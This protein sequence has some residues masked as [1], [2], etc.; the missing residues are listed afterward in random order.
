M[1]RTLKQQIF[2]QKIYLCHVMQY[3]KE[4]VS[5]H[6][7]NMFVQS[8]SELCQTASDSAACLAKNS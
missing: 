7:D 4:F 3:Q 6:A 5:L 8:A 2:A 1:L